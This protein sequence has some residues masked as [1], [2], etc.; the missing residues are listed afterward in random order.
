MIRGDWEM[1]RGDI[2]RIRGV[3]DR[4]WERVTG[5]WEMEEDH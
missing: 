1:I 5:S 4:I 3:R 2:D